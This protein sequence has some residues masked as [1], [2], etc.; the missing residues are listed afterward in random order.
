MEQKNTPFNSEGFH[1][2]NLLIIIHDVFKR[3]LLIVLAAAVVGVG[4]YVMADNSYTPRYRTTTTFVVTSRTSNTSV[5]SNLNNANTLAGVFSELINSSILRKSI[6]AEIDEESFGGSINASVISGT[7]LITVT[8]TDTNP[9]TTFLVAQAI[10]DHHEDVTYQV[11]DNVTL[12]VLQ[13]PTVP[14]V[15][16]NS[17]SA[18][19]NMKRN[20]ILAAL[21]ATALLAFLSYSQDNIR[22]SSDAQRKLDC[23]YLGEIPHEKKYKTILSMLRR[24]KTGILISSP[25]TGFRYVE[26]I[27]KLRHRVEQRMHGGKVLMVTSLLENE[28]KSTVAVNL[29]MTMA[30]KHKKVLL[31]DCD[32]RKPAC[33]MLLQQKNPDLGI[34]DV[35]SGKANAANAVTRYQSTNLYML[36]EKR[37]SKA[38]VDMIASQKMTALLE[39]ARNQFDL[40]VLD[41]P[42]M[43]VASDAER[44]ME[45]ADA[46]LL[47]VRQNAA[48]TKALA[49]AIASLKSG[50]ANLLGCVL[51]NVRSTSSF[52]EYGY[53]KHNYYGRYGYGPRK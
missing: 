25:T 35:L 52:G 43:A 16:I 38:A 47:V 49:K 22:S 19:Y 36:L 44:V 21:A 5:Y 17:S 10:V 9:R 1:P 8:V 48:P 6:L 50:K 33:H 30:Q 39:W 24:R 4:S 51:N 31:I 28:G 20:A 2:L 41:L 14:M 3:W 11:V 12:E 34:S 18:S 45:I 13:Y 23:S 42:P 29:A 27:R 46:S 53:G 15:P 37:S 40:V 32:L 7:N 26:N